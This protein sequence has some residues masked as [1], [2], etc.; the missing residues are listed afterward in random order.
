MTGRQCS[1]NQPCVKCVEDKSACEYD[2]SSDKRRR[3]S[4]RKLEELVHDSN[5]L[6][7]LVAH[8]QSGEAIDAPGE[9]SAVSLIRSGAS[10]ADLGLWLQRRRKEHANSKIKR[11]MSV[12]RLT[13]RAPIS[14]PAHPWTGITDD[15]FIASHLVSLC[16]TWPESTWAHMIDHDCFIRDMRSGD[17][18]SPCCSPLLAN[19]VMAHGCV[20]SCPFWQ[21]NMY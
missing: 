12:D 4:K 19:L 8:L 21:V 2:A 5:V 16:F 14:V 20:S 10:K 9:E 18:E 1:G 13:D 6:D 17:R 11:L 15:D 7:E 3:A